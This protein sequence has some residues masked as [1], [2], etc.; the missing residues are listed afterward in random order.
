MHARKQKR[1]W[2]KWRWAQ[3]RNVLVF[4]DNGYEV[5]LDTAITPAGMLDWIFQVYR[6]SWL[7]PQ[8]VFDL[9][10]AL[11]DTVEPQKNLCSL[12][13]DVS[14]TQQPGH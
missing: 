12:G 9:L 10:Q 13:L 11:D 14:G 6:K 3:R 2:G 8:D 1:Q 5:D 4:E 7:T